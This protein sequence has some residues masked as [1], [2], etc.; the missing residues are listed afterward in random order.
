MTLGERSAADTDLD[1]LILFFSSRKLQ[2][3]A[4]VKAGGAR[5]R[6]EIDAFRMAE[7]SK[8][9]SDT[10]IRQIVKAVEQ[11]MEMHDMTGPASCP[12]A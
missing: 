12:P 2:P 6:K 7:R 8:G 1:L 9:T 10:D 5:L 11:W 4:M 3:R